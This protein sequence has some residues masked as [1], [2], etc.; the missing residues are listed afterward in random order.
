MKHIWNIETQPEI[1]GL[2]G[3]V[4]RGMS[5]RAGWMAGM[6]SMKGMG[7]STDPDFIGYLAYILRKPAKAG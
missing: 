2:A 1:C 7:W 6:G 3:R 4:R 5:G